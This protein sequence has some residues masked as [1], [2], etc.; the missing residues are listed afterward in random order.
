[1]KYNEYYNNSV[2][3]F[4]QLARDLKK[5]GFR[6]E[7]S[8]DGEYMPVYYLCYLDYVEIALTG[9][10]DWSV[11]YYHPFKGLEIYSESF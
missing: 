7:I 2:M 11:A 3:N 4:R 6:C 10:K 5:Q 8:E 9:F 1:M